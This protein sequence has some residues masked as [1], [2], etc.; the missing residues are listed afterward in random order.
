LLS[1]YMSSAGDANVTNVVI[2]PRSLGPGQTDGPTEVTISLRVT[3]SQVLETVWVD[4]D[5]ARSD[6]V[7]FTQATLVLEHGDNP[8]SGTWR[9]VISFPPNLPDGDY[10]ISYNAFAQGSHRPL[11]R[12]QE[13]LIGNVSVQRSTILDTQRPEIL[14]PEVESHVI[15][16]PSTGNS[17][18]SVSAEVRD[19]IGV[20]F[21]AAIGW[22]NVPQ[23]YSI[24]GEG[25]IPQLSLESGNNN[26]AQSGRWTGRL[27]IP[28]Q[29]P[30]GEYHIHFYAFDAAGNMTVSEDNLTL[31]VE[32][33]TSVSDSVAP[34]RVPSSVAPTR[35]PSSVAPA[36]QV[37]TGGDGH[38]IT[39]AFHGP[40][41]LQNITSDSGECEIRISVPRRVVIGCE[42]PQNSAYR[43][44]QDSTGREQ[45]HRQLISLPKI[46]KSKKTVI[47][48]LSIAAIVI[49][50]AILAS[51]FTY[52][53]QDN[54]CNSWL[55]RLQNQI[56]SI[57]S[58]LNVGPS[59]SQGIT[60]R[61]DTM[62]ADFNKE[63]SA[64]N[65]ECGRK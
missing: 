36:G 13:S 14:S 28:R 47:P 38:A 33:T 64:Y 10:V 45:V 39:F 29:Y 43:V 58:E 26:T 5:R 59:K 23:N 1:I 63:I 49:A 25:N 50:G 41:T 55:T 19:N 34:T 8:H 31:S 52:S 57:N 61:I 30:S 53:F 18:V 17:Y 24:L 54:K 9:G 12:I 16:V 2:E 44:E 51:Y 7:V 15:H 11:V 20:V 48:I 46:L 62:A 56:L 65:E 3:S 42:C 22:M 60:D 4:A 35:V 27:I 32:T 21:V 40:A 6:G 37:E